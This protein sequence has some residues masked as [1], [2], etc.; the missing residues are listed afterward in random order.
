MIKMTS[1]GARSLEYDLLFMLD[2]LQL[3]PEDAAWFA[4]HAEPPDDPKEV[5]AVQA[6]LQKVSDTES[7]QHRFTQE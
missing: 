4:A 1:H 5:L 3:L 2:A 6:Q 7:Q